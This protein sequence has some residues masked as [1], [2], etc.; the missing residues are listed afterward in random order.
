[1]ILEVWYLDRAYSGS[2]SVLLDRCDVVYQSDRE[3]IPPARMVMFAMDPDHPVLNEPNRGL[4]FTDTISF[5]WDA[6]NKTPYDTG[7]LVEPIPG[8]NAIP[9]LGVNPDSKTGYATLTECMDGKMLLQ[10]FSSHNLT[11][12]AMRPLW[13]NMVYNA[14]RRH[15]TP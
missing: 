11:F 10:T 6:V 12:N 1:V 9:I 2:A 4:T 14:L 7:D 5:W 15:F 8:K 3:K 13:E